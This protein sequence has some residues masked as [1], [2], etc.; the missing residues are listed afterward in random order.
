MN[1]QYIANF[2]VNE[3]RDQV[4]PRMTYSL[5]CGS[6]TDDIA[7]VLFY[8]RSVYSTRLALF[9]LH[10]YFNHSKQT[11]TEPLV[12]DLT[13]VELDMY[14]KSDAGVPV[15]LLNN[16]WMGHTSKKLRIIEVQVYPIFTGFKIDSPA[17]MKAKRMNSRLPRHLSEFFK[18]MVGQL[19]DSKSKQITDGKRKDF[20][21]SIS[22]LQ[23][24]GGVRRIVN[25][26]SDDVVNHEDTTSKCMIYPCLQP[27]VCW[28]KTGLPIDLMCRSKPQRTVTVRSPQTFFHCHCENSE[29]NYRNCYPHHL[30]QGMDISKVQR[31]NYLRLEIPEG[32]P[33]LSTQ[34]TINFDP[35]NVDKVQVLGPDS[36]QF[37][38]T[39]NCSKSSGSREFWKRD[40][41]P[42]TTPEMAVYFDFQ[43][44]IGTSLVYHLHWPTGLPAPKLIDIKTSGQEIKYHKLNKPFAVG[45]QYFSIAKNDTTSATV[46]VHLLASYGVVMKEFPTETK[47]KKSTK[48]RTDQRKDRRDQWSNQRK[49][50]S[51]D[52]QDRCISSTRGRSP[53]RRG[54]GSS[55]H[56]GRKDH[57]KAEREPIAERSQIN[58]QIARSE[59][60]CSNRNKSSRYHRSKRRS[61]N[62]NINTYGRF[63]N[64]PR[65]TEG[66]RVGETSSKV[67]F[68]SFPGKYSHARYSSRR[69]QCKCKALSTERYESKIQCYTSIGKP[70]GGC[71][72]TRSSNENPSNG[73]T[74]TIFR[75]RRHDQRLVSRS[76]ANSATVDSTTQY[77][78]ANQDRPRAFTSTNST[79]STAANAATESATD[80]AASATAVSTS[81]TAPIITSKSLSESSTTSSERSSGSAAHGSSANGSSAK[82]ENSAVD[83]TERKR[84]HSEGSE[85]QGNKFEYPSKAAASTTPAAAATIIKRKRLTSLGEPTAEVLQHIKQYLDA[86]LP[87]PTHGP[88][89]PLEE[90]E[91]LDLHPEEELN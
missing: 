70:K 62:S 86:A 75:G 88:S 65:S 8:P 44:M 55:T 53:R 26:H 91:Y 22:T 71:H 14:T 36:T 4:N 1:K 76:M 52:Q 9:V 37:S 32:G 59:T 66:Q 67:A 85:Y 49:E 74:R 21:T 29:L 16:N 54:L 6:L 79:E 42:E 58:I 73:S 57:R 31:K 25:F 18:C 19:Q 47:T 68:P 40:D 90:S 15:N 87:Q 28:G 51:R 12:Y 17:Q 11:D 48:N 27:G 84:S 13:R 10:R 23:I 3:S 63:R 34:V 39:L 60:C 46:E 7:K 82:Y 2:Y 81:S 30:R 24:L 35:E 69:F 45:T 83:R 89:H 64:R 20:T 38:I 50:S 80:V 77:R 56:N 41:C 72:T 33:Q 61:T 78:K 5:S 43:T